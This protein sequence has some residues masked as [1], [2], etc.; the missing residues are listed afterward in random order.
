MLVIDQYIVNAINGN[1]SYCIMLKYNKVLKRNSMTAQKTAIQ[2]KDGQQLL[3]VGSYRIVAFNII[4]AALLAFYLYNN[5]VPTQILIKWLSAIVIII[6]IRLFH[7]KLVIKKELYISHTNL[8]L[9]IFVFFTLLTGLVWT[10]IFFAS[11][12]YTDN[13]MRFV[14]FIVFAGMCAGAT[15]SLGVYM[16][17]F[18]VYVCAIFLPII[19]YNLYMGGVNNSILS[20]ILSFYLLATAIIAKSFQRL[21]TG[22]FYLTEQNEILIDKLEELS[23]TDS[24]TAL[25]NR[26]H[27]TK[28]IKDEYYRAKRNKYSLAFISIDVDNFK[29]VNDN[30]GHPFGDKFLT[31]IAY[32]LKSY[33]RRENDIIFRLGGDEFAALLINCSEEDTKQICEQIKAGFL[34]TPGFDYEPQDQ[35]HKKILDQVSLSIGVVFIPYETELNV[36]QITEMADQLLYDAKHHGK[37][38]VMYVKI[39]A[40]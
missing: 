29:L 9:K 36:N 38:K 18:L 10:S 33:L 20:I 8:N 3:Y 6:G 11:N 26:R 35:E 16:F 28:L 37:S 12:P 17:A 27:F 19:F 15:A 14:I 21:L 30:F 1:G 40:K 32:Y 13:A 22:I 25:Y 23:I 7:C 34:K 31:Y 4:L 5:N 39:S 2:Y 24:L